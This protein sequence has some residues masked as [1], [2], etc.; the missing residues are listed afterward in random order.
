MAMITEAS[1]KGVV[2]LHQ[3]RGQGSPTH[4][5][6]EAMEKDMGLFLKTSILRRIRCSN[7]GAGSSQLLHVD[8]TSQQ[9][10]HRRVNANAD[11]K[12]VD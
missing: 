5:H 4:R 12:Y 2:G 1:V 6:T 11:S 7:P 8:A 3:L 9:P 10:L